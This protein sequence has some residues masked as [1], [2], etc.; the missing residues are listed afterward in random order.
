MAQDKNG[1][2]SNGIKGMW[3]K[4]GANLAFLA[5]AGYM[6][7][8]RMGT[9]SVWVVVAMVAI[10]ALGLSIGLW[11]QREQV[12]QV[13]RGLPG[14]LFDAGK[15]R[16]W[17]TRPLAVRIYRGVFVGLTLVVTLLSVAGIVL[18]FVRGQR[19]NAALDTALVVT[20]AMVLLWKY[21]GGRKRRPKA[22]RR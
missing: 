8:R 12:A 14:S 6:I 2:N 15:R 19:G 20:F 1:C 16:V 22:L 13:C 17:A 7:I 3:R 11:R 21:I 10:W 5:V 18:Y 9:P 4:I